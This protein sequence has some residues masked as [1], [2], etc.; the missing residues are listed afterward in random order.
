M[1]RRIHV[2]INPA[3]GQDKPI[4][5]VLN[6]AFG[7][8]G[9][10]WEVFITKEAG[11]AT[12]LA[13]KAVEEGVDAVAVHGGDGTVG[14]VAAGLVDSTVPMAIVPGGTANAMSIELGI[15]SDPAEACA[16][17]AS[18]DSQVRQVDMGQ[19]GDHYFVLRVGMGLEAEMVKNASREGKAQMGNLA[20]VVA[21]R[22]A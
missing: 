19:V 16:L 10:D 12:R 14:E 13:R 1:Y 21:A 9:V 20:Y 15:P 3:A 7:P 2:I 8:A 22:Q 17:V 5:G 18:E 4:L 6:K 11:D